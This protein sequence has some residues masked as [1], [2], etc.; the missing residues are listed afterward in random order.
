MLVVGA[1][2]AAFIWNKARAKEFSFEKDTHC[3]CGKSDPIGPRQSIRFEARKGERP[4]VVVKN[5]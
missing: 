2:A 5:G 1:T 4:R 3:G